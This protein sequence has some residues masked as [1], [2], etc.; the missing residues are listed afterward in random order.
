MM[1]DRGRLGLLSRSSRLGMVSGCSLLVAGCRPLS[2]SATFAVE[3]TLATTEKRLKMIPPPCH[4]F[5]QSK[6][7]GLTRSHE[8]HEVWNAWV[9]S[10]L[11]GFVS[12]CERLGVRSTPDR[13]SPLP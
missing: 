3:R 8:E 6:E 13:L 5:L 4:K 10:P 9:Q 1:I 7:F 2:P 12:L 11:C